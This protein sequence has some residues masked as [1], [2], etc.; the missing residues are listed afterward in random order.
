VQRTSRA[1]IA[2]ELAPWFVVLGYNFFILIAARAICSA[3]RAAMNMPNRN[4][5]RPF[6]CGRLGHLSSH[7]FVT[8]AGARSRIFTSPTVLSCLYV[9]IA[10]LVLATTRNPDFGVLVA[11]GDRVVRLQDAISMCTDITPWA[12][13]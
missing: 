3:L 6:G 13:S 8:L 7:L 1:R 9:T 2:G 5:M 12:S 10:V 11:I 4:G